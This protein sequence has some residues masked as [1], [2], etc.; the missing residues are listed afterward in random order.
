M[1]NDKRAPNQLRDIKIERGWQEA[2]EGSVLVSFG[3]TKV[4]CTATFDTSVPRWMKD[5]GRGWVTSEYEML[6][7][8]NNERNSRESR[9][10]KIGGRTHEI[11]RLIGRSLRA[12]V[13]LEALGEAQIIIDCDVLQADGGTRCASITGGWVALKDA[14]LWGKENGFISDIDLVLEKQIAAVSV[15]ILNN[16]PI[17]DLPYEED[18]RAETDMNVV[19]ASNGEYVE[20]Q[21]TAERQ[22]FNRD[23]LN[24]LLDLANEGCGELFKLQ[25]NLYK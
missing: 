19:M 2:G 17:L 24:Q 13:N 20:I 22:T 14:L 23:E 21:G 11:S 3:N 4:L 12:A 9:K 7:R 15:G 5:S 6:P 25:N 1:R 16:T 18:S 8:A 10:G